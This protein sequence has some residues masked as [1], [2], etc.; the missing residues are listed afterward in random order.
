MAIYFF[1]MQTEK[2][3]NMIIILLLTLEIMSMYIL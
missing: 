1:G 2:N 3:V